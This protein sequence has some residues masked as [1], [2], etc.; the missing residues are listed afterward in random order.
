MIIELEKG[1]VHNVATCS[2]V[3]CDVKKNKCEK[4]TLIISNIVG[5][6]PEGVR[7]IQQPLIDLQ[8]LNLLD[9]IL[10]CYSQYNYIILDSYISETKREIILNKM[11]KI[12]TKNK[13]V[14]LS[15]QNEKMGAV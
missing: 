5:H 9:D 14:I 6:Y 8:M 15:I 7:V 10:E 1:K 12:A 13:V 11:D 2:H 4:N 3:M